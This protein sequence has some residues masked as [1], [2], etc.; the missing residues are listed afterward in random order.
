MQ[1]S[2]NFKISDHTASSWNRIGKRLEFGRDAVRQRIAI[3]VEQHRDRL[4]ITHDPHDFDHAALPEL[5]FG[6]VEGGV[7]HLGGAEQFGAE[8]VDGLLVRL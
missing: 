5:L 6:G 1:E 2:S 7:V 3:R 4:V 8:V